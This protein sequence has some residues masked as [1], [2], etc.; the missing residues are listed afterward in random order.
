MY[1]YLGFSEV[2]VFFDLS[3]CG[4]AATPPIKLVDTLFA[5][6]FCKLFAEFA[7][8]RSVEVLLG[9]V[10]LKAVEVLTALL[11]TSPLLDPVGPEFTLLTSPALDILSYP[12]RLC[13]EPFV[14]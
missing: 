12:E 2:C 9:W 13:A 14:L 5:L 10:V 11:V 4:F 8:L 1:V 6:L 3:S 7:A